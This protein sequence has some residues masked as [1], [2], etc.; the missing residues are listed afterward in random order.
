M[1]NRR[2]GHPKLRWAIVVVTLLFVSLSLLL[3]QVLKSARWEKGLKDKYDYQLDVVY[4]RVGEV[5]NKLDIYVPKGANEPRPTLVWFHGG[6]WSHNS[7]DQISGQ[8]VPFLESGW[9]VV[10]VDY[11]LVGQAL[12]PAAVVDC[13]CALFWVYATAKENKIDTRKI[14]VAGTSAGAHL[15]L[16]AGMLP[17]GN[18]LDK[19]CN[20]AI[21]VNVAAILDFYGPTYLDDALEGPSRNGSVVRWIGNQAEKKEIAHRVSPMSYVRPD[22][23]PIFIVH[24]D[25]DPTVPYDQSVRLHKAL[26]EA[27]VPNEFYT[28]PGGKHG[29][30]E[31]EENQKIMR[32]VGEFLVRHGFDKLFDSERK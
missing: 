6:G 1:Q 22:L 32:A 17:S 28:V 18:P 5:E 8:L 12:A 26:D 9:V 24:G 10:N 15:A 19:E 16:M 7:K 11:R 27:R 21:P 14:V 30:F 13:R 20:N 31:K 3:A 4:S 25:A 29:G 2:S 23:P